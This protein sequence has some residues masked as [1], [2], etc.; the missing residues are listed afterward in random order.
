MLTAEQFAKVFDMA[1]L[2]QDTQEAAIREACK[3]AREYNLAALY[4]TPCWSHIVASELKGTDVRAGAGI[5]FPYG[6]NTSK[7]KF[8]EMEETLKLGC[9]ALDMVIN[10]G[11]LKDK[12]YDLVK[13]EIKQLVNV[14][15]KDALAKI[16]YEVCFLTDEEIAVL[17]QICC[18]YGADYVKT[19]TGSEGLPDVKHLK[20]IKANL[21]GKTKLKLSGVPRQF[22]LAACLWM[23]DMGVEL[24]GTRSAAKLVDEY[25]EYLA[26]KK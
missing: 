12:N 24:I 22:T 4:T 26:V 16:I 25:K 1:V 7:A 2:K 19:A 8:I 5:G 10:I 3:T 23:L 14:C 21:S 20:V 13:N 18:E 9:T 15:G 6:T 11:A 17:T